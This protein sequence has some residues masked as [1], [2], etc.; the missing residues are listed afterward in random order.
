MLNES[1]LSRIAGFTP[2][3]RWALAAAA[4][5]LYIPIFLVLFSLLYPL[6][7]D[8]ALAI[9]FLPT[10]AWAVLL[11]PRLAALGSLLLAIPNFLFLQAFESFVSS[12]QTIEL[13]VTH[14]VIAVISYGAG[15]TSRLRQRLTAELDLRMA[16]EARFR[17]LFERNSDAVFITDPSM[18][19]I[20]VNE[21]AAHLLGYTA[22][23]LIGKPYHD[24]VVPEEHAGLDVR[25][26]QSQAGAKV[27]LGE[28]TYICKDGSLITAEVS[29]ALIQNRDGTPLHFQTI[30]RDIT[31][32]K[33]AQ[34]QIYYEA[35][36]DSLTGLYNRAMIFELL[37]R[38]MERTR[39][40]QNML[41]VLYLDLDG[42][43]RVNDTHGHAMGDLLLKAC[44]DRIK[45]L[46]RKTDILGRVG[47]DEFTIVLEGL[48][49][50]DFAKQVAANIER[51]LG[52]VFVLDG[53]QIEISTSVGISFFPEDAEDSEALLHKAD[54]MMYA[55]KQQKKHADL[56]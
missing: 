27:P 19:V 34:E 14:F 55:V 7:G 17:G 54:Q 37:N 26:N 23:E 31:V 48:A 1:S 2:R 11:G 33:A 35:T 16:S 44:A 4:L 13:L 28:R 22:K 39:R 5:A 56:S 8:V 3:K 40:N 51:S 25:I 52:E 41:A 42:F 9:A 43:K 32:R 12:Q 30:S 10:L 45:T 46:L 24:L 18:T 36:H 15:N 21:A 50:K 6:I 38:A 53:K 20:D 47:G 49:A 29:G